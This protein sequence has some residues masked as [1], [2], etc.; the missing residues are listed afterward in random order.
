MDRLQ[1]SKSIN[2]KSKSKD[3]S[4]EYLVKNHFNKT[5]ALYNLIGDYENI[6]VQGTVSKNNISFSLLFKTKKEAVEMHNI[7]NDTCFQIYNEVCHV[8]S[9][10]NNDGKTLNINIQ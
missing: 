5:M 4:V 9:S 2:C 3:I 7:V 8:I 10:I 6:Q 1:F